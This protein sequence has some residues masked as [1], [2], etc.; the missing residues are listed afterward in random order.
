MAMTK[1]RLLRE[2]AEIAKDPDGEAS[3]SRADDALLN[4]IGDTEISAAY[5]AAHPG[6]CA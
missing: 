5:Q 4:Y 1:A 3:H 6:W 2:L